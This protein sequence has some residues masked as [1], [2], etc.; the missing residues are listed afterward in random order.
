MCNKKNVVVAVMSDAADSDSDGDVM[1]SL[2]DAEQTVVKVKA[3][4]SDANKLTAVLNRD[5]VDLCSNM[6]MTSCKFY[7]ITSAKR[8]ILP[9]ICPFVFVY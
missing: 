8:I 4:T 1:T 2:D 3:E 9:G 6:Q 5:D 7:L